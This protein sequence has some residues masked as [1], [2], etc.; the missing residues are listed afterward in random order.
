MLKYFDFISALL[1]YFPITLG[2]IFTYFMSRKIRDEFGVK[3]PKR[4]I[5]AFLFVVVVAFG[6]LA[7]FQSQL[8]VVNKASDIFI[9]Q[10]VSDL[11]FTSTQTVTLSPITASELEDIANK[12]GV[13]INLTCVWVS[14]WVSFGLFV[15]LTC[16]EIVFM[17]KIP[18][19]MFYY[20]LPNYKNGCIMTKLKQ[21]RTV[22]GPL[23][24]YIRKYKFIKC[25][26]KRINKFKK[27]SLKEKENNLNNLGCMAANPKQM[28]TARRLATDYIK[29][30]VVKFDDDMNSFLVSY[31]LFKHMFE[32]IRANCAE[33]QVGP[34]HPF[35]IFDVVK[36]LFDELD[37][38][39]INSCFAVIEGLLLG[40]AHL[41]I[42][43]SFRIDNS[44]YDFRYKDLHLSFWE[45]I[46]EKI[47][48]SEQQ[49]LASLECLYVLSYM[50]KGGELSS[51]TESFL[52]MLPL[53]EDFENRLLPSRYNILKPFVC[54]NQNG[55]FRRVDGNPRMLE[56]SDGSNLR[57]QLK[58]IGRADKVIDR[59]MDK[60]IDEQNKIIILEKD[61]IDWLLG[62][63]ERR[64]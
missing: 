46:T 54:Q 9:N 43:H 10:R 49:K 27:Y 19:R 56:F 33:G 7:C 13:P 47:E 31:T 20:D 8:A 18:S 44:I 25:A 3:F 63:N 2:A 1:I 52:S 64:V 5:V 35:K 42:Y 16:I 62:S 32:N 6:L 15:I 57:A 24:D 11:N 40:F 26:V 60:I 38:N 58:I 41:Y 22:L 17:A 55:N 48:S 36:E 53:K 21:M 34:E 51:S 30:V 50:R 4:W 39:N 28:N 59:Q 14:G 37:K 29:D 23:T 61:K 45:K 12:I